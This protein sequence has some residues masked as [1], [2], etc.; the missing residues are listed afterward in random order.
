M[1]YYRQQGFTIIE[2]MITLVVAAVLAMAA[3]PSF[4]RTI[5][6]N[7]IASAVNDFNT[8]LALAKSEAVKRNR[9]VKIV[10]NTANWVDGYVIGVDLNGDDDFVDADETRIKIVAA[11]ATTITIVP[12]PN[13]LSVVEINNLGGMNNPGSFVF[14]STRY[15]CTRT[16]NMMASGVHIL[17]KEQ[18]PCS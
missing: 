2:L 8:S 17:Q 10:S 7:R 4:I 12:D 3:T 1:I 16:I 9:S 11:A 13:P 15:A 6:K 14:D 18:E 5:D